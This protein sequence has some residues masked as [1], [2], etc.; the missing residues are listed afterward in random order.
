MKKQNDNHKSQEKK[1]DLNNSKDNNEKGDNVVRRIKIRG[2]Y[3][4]IREKST[5]KGKKGTIKGKWKPLRKPRKK[6]I[7]DWFR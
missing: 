3:Y 7:W 2:K 4:T 6:S 5:V 1:E